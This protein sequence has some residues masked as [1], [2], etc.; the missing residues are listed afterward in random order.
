MK[1]LSKFTNCGYLKTSITAKLLY[2]ILNS[3]ADKKGAVVVPQRR[4][5]R[6]LGISK[7][8][9]SRNLHRLEKVGAIKIIARYHD[10]GGRAANLYR[11]L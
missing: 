2:L 8:T 7:G 10:D 11:V 6:V 4:I 1:K 9:V 5:C 3:L